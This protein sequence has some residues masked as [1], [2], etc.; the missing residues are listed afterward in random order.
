MK[1]FPEVI[2]P[3]KGN[4]CGLIPIMQQLNINANMGLHEIKSKLIKRSM[5]LW[6]KQLHENAV[7]KEGKLRTYNMFKQ[8][9]KCEPY[10]NAVTNRD[11]RKSFTRFRVSAHDLAI[12]RG[13]IKI[14]NLKI[15]FVKI[16]KRRKLK[17]KFIS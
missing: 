5:E 13:D 14:L 3:V 8:I 9:F 2:Q 15:E 4:N 16:V 10:L 7:I 11:V 12:E 6:G 17:M 1:V